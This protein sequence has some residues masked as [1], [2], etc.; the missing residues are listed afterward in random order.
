MLRADKP[1]H[2]A[3]PEAQQLQL[4]SSAAATCGDA[5]HSGSRRDANDKC[6]DELGAPAPAARHAEGIGMAAQ[7]AD[8][9]NGCSGD[10]VAAYISSGSFRARPRLGQLPVG[11]L[12]AWACSP[13][14]TVVWQRSGS[15]TMGSGGSEAEAAGCR[16]TELGLYSPLPT[17]GAAEPTLVL[18]AARDA[19]RLG[20]AANSTSRLPAR[21]REVRRRRWVAA[22]RLQTAWRQRLGRRRV[23]EER[24]RQWAQ[25]RAAT[26]ARAEEAAR[27]IAKRHSQ[28][29]RPSPR[30]ILEAFAHAIEPQV[31]APQWVLGPIRRPAAAPPAEQAAGLA[32]PAMGAADMRRR[33]VPSTGSIGPQLIGWR[34]GGDGRS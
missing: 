34:R 20:H 15:S 28:E 29:S 12:P 7:P 13:S 4:D 26:R 18:A 11:R 27:R 32:T 33:A 5:A 25:K 19:E 23:A 6:K 22:V 3:Q 10:C 21:P 17:A 30:Q 2:F 8:A 31:V 9:P 24:R 14:V 1:W 16:V